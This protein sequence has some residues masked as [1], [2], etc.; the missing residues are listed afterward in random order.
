MLLLCC[1]VDNAVQCLVGVLSAGSEPELQLQAAWC[2]TNMAAGT[3]EQA[4]LAA[5]EAA[6][7]LITYLSSSNEQLQV[8]STLSLN[9]PLQQQRTATGRQH[10]IS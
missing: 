10:P 2:F 1:S 4:L 8:G 6:P 5:K 9:I 3:D 7:Y